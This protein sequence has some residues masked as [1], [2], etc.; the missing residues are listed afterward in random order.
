MFAW[1]A[2]AFA[3]G[4]DTA[5]S[6]LVTA[7]VST[8]TPFPLIKKW[9]SAK[10]PWE[11]WFKANRYNEIVTDYGD[12]VVIMWNAEDFKG[13]YD[14]KD[15]EQ[16][17][18]E[19][20]FQLAVR[21]YPAGAKA[22]QVKVDIVYMQEDPNYGKPLMDTLQQVAHFELLRSKALKT[23]KTKKKLSPAAL[24]KIFDQS[25]VY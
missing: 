10:V 11:S 13:N 16:R 4:Q 20:A 7:T 8:P 2:V 14:G 1:M 25:T 22:D 17:L 12:H 19:T 18:K 24:Q 23:A 5:P 3:L 6:A 15:K 21:L 9:D